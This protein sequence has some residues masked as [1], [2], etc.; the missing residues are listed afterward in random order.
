MES[1]YLLLYVRLLYNMSYIC[2]HV[3]G[4]SSGCPNTLINLGR[5]GPCTSACETSM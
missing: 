4:E 1:F 3:G 2:T 5:E